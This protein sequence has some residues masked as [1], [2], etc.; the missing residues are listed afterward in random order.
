MNTW[1][2]DTLPFAGA[3]YRQ[4]IVDFYRENRFV[5]GT[6]TVRG[7]R[8]ELKNIRASLLNVLASTDHIVP[9]QQSEAIADLVGSEDKETMRVQGGHIGL[10]AGSGAKKGTW[11]HINAWLGSRSGR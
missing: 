5:N 1:V 2:T 7:E 11:P 9:C 6:L 10:M 3:A 4:L 8:A